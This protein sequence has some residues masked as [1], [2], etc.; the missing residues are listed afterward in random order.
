MTEVG[1]TVYLRGRVTEVRPDGSGHF[2]WMRSSKGAV[3]PGDLMEIPTKAGARGVA[4]ERVAKLDAAVKKAGTRGLN[5]VEK[6][7]YSDGWMDAYH[8]FFCNDE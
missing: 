6:A 4:H 8:Y 3:M 7:C 2:D 5:E 1:D